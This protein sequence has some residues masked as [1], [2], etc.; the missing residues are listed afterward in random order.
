MCPRR[1][2]M[3]PCNAL[4][5]IQIFSKIRSKKHGIIYE[6]VYTRGG[7]TGAAKLKQTLSFPQLDWLTFTKKYFC[8]ILQFGQ[9]SFV[10]F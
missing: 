3:A 6:Y 7:G 5:R 10:E 8:Q 4:D 9:I 2:W 1:L